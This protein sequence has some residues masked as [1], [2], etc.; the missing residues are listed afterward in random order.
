MYI[1]T[2]KE[3]KNSCPLTGINKNQIDIF[4]NGIIVGYIPNKIG[5]IHY[6]IDSIEQIEEF[7]KEV[8]KYFDPLGYSI[9][10]HC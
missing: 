4:I 8:K 3:N 10:V 1:I 9:I 7:K 2:H 5:H 6:R